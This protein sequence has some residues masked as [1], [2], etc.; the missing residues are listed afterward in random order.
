MDLAKLS[1]FS[2]GAEAT[3]APPLTG[4]A[5]ARAQALRQKLTL[6]GALSAVLGVLAFM[7]LVWY[8]VIQEDLKKQFQAAAE[9]QLAASQLQ[10]YGQL[11]AAGNP[12]AF[13]QLREIDQAFNRNLE[14]LL[15]GSATLAPAPSRLVPLVS[16]V[17]Q[18]WGPVKENLS[19]LLGYEKPLTDLDARSRSINAREGQMLELAEQIFGAL[20]TGGSARDL[21]FAGQ[22]VAFATRIPQG[23]RHMLSRADPAPWAKEL[24]TGNRAYQ[25]A[26]K[27]LAGNAA[28]RE[29]VEKLAGIHGAITPDINTML[30]NLKALVAAKQAAAPVIAASDKVL[31]E[32]TQRLTEAFGR[33][34]SSGVWEGMLTAILAA[35]AA[36][37]AILFTRVLVA[38][39]RSRQGQS[40]LENRRNQEAI[41]RLLDE[42]GSLAEGDL[43]VNAS[44]TED[45]TGAIA[46]SINFTVS[47]LRGLVLR[48]NETTQRVA[49]AS[50]QAQ[51]ISNQLLAAAERQSGE[52]KETTSAVLQMAQSINNVSVNAAES[53]KV[54][55][56]SLSAARKGAAAVQNSISGMNEIRGQIQ[57]TAKRIKRLGESSQEIDEIVELISDITE[58]TNVL[59]LNAAIQAASA[60]EAG[61]G[62]SVVAEEVQRLAERSAQATKQISGIVKTIQ[63]D[64]QDA[65][66][67]MEKSTQG[68]VEGARLSDAAGQALAEIGQVSQ[69]LAEM[70]TGISTATRTQ[71]DSATQ[72]ATSMRDILAITDQTTEGTKLT[73]HSI[74][75][76]AGLASELRGSVANFKV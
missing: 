53:A 60:G 52:I 9:M 36:W 4:A 32:S 72:M 13:P 69:D 3:A 58:Q 43:T 2:P 14:G 64:T 55:Q 16:E 31:L 48:I 42:M 39:A 61:R 41:L 37:F 23:A 65:V 66:A 20:A 8:I 51:S 30:A 29:R 22:L 11:G 68:V 74:G 24:D 54:A 19:A 45:M 25:D 62:F 76:L 57:E 7:P 15:Q 70:I 21:Y 59:A 35:L 18:Q 34:T 44:V 33:Q 26:L 71:A 1:L 75:E 40:E 46:D 12:A 38:E 63:A 50:Q 56:Q 67:A 5:L 27:A 17:N 47:E 10:K 73:A 49:E 28:V 6:W